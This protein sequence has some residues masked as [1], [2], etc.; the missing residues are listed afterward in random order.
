MPTESRLQDYIVMN[1]FMLFVGSLHLKHLALIPHFSQSKKY[2]KDRANG[3][4]FKTCVCGRLFVYKV[5]LLFSLL[6]RIFVP[7]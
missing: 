2:I 3:D 7:G 4:K 6:Y 1:E 5:L